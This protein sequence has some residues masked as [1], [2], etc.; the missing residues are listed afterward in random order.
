[1][2]G[3]NGWAEWSKHVLRELERLN[4]HCVKMDEKMDGLESQIIE[5]RVR[6]TMMGTLFGA[7]AGMGGGS[8]I[9]LALKLLGTS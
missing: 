2:T 3:E 7:L 8:L 4:A 9:P 6:S 1:M 5:F